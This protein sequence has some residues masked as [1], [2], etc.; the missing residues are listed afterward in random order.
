MWEKH[1]AT[2]ALVVAIEAQ[3]QCEEVEAAAKECGVDE[4]CLV[5]EDEALCEPKK[6]AEASDSCNFW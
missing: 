3:R 5:V 6:S 2:A 1:L 4:E